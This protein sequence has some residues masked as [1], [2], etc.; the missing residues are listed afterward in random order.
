MYNFDSESKLLKEA[1][2][3]FEVSDENDLLVKIEKLLTDQK[4]RI[5]MGQKALKVV[6]NQ[7]GA[8]N[9]NIEI[10]KRYINE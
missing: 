1:E 6:E 9:K 10:I 8:I 2:A 5:N 4:L 7:T 3:S